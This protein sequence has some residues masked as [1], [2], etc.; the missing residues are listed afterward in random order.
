MKLTYL[1][2]DTLTDFG[3]VLSSSNHGIVLVDENNNIVA[4]M[5]DA[6]RPATGDTLDWTKV[7]EA[8]FEL[9]EKGITYVIPNDNTTIA[10]WRTVEL[11]FGGYGMDDYWGTTPLIGADFDTP[12]TKNSGETYTLQDND[13]YLE[14][15]PLE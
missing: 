13:V 11:I 1:S 4:D 8:R 5:D 15:K 12:I 3:D 7:S 9:D 14:V 10:G 2:S 6:G